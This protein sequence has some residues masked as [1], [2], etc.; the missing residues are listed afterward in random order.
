[1]RKRAWPQPSLHLGRPSSRQ[2]TPCPC[3]ERSWGHLLSGWI[4]R[5]SRSF[6]T[7]PLSTTT[8]RGLSHLERSFQTSPSHHSQER[9]FPPGEK[10][11][12]KPLTPQPG[13][14]FPAWRE[15]S[16]P[17]SHTTAR[18]D[19]SRLE[20]SFQTSPSHH[21]QERP[22]PPR[23]RLPDQP[24]TPQPGEAF[25]TWREA[26]RPAPHTTAREAL[27][28]W[29][30]L[31]DQPLSPSRRAFPPER[32]PDQPLHH[33]QEALPT[34][35]EA[36][37]PAPLTTARRGLTHLE[38]S[39][40]TSPSHHSQERP[41]PPGEK[42]PD[43]P[44]SPQPGEALPTW[45]EAPRPAPLTPA[46]RDLSH[47]E[48]GF[49]T[50]PSHH[51]QGHWRGLPDQPTPGGLPTW[52][53][54]SNQ[55]LTPQPGEALP[56]WREASQ[57]SPSHH[58]QETPP[59]ESPTR[60]PSHLER[61]RPAPTPGGLHPPGSQ[62]PS[63][64]ARKAFPTR[65]QTSPHKPGGHPLKRPA[66]LTAARRPHH[67]ER[68]FQTSHHSQERPHLERSWDKP[69]HSQARRGLSHLERSFQTSP[70][71]GQRPPRKL[72]DQPFTPGEALPGIPALPAREAPLREANQPLSPRQ[73]PPT[74]RGFQTSPSHHSQER[75]YPPG[76]KLPDQPL[77]PQPGEALPTWREASRPALHTTARRPPRKAPQPPPGRHPPGLPD[78]P[79]HP[80]QET[81]LEAPAAPLTTPEA[82]PKLQTSPLTT[83]RG[84]FP[85]GEKLPDQP[86]TP[87]PEEAFPAWGKIAPFI[88]VRDCY[89]ERC[90]HFGRGHCLGEGVTQS[91]TGCSSVPALCPSDASSSTSRGNQ[92]CLQTLSCVPG[93]S[94]SALSQRI[95]SCSV[96]PAGVQW[97]DL[98]SLKP[99]PPRF[100]QFSCL[101]FPSSWDYRNV[102][103][104]PASVCVCVCVCVSRDGVSPYWPG[105]SGTPDL[106]VRPPRPPKITGVSHCAPPEITFILSHGIVPNVSLLGKPDFVTCV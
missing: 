10:L 79:L 103:S 92:G 99:S 32:L 94:P 19:L 85:P 56:T 34:W 52:R 62:P 14:T 95:E 29:K 69:Q 60:R 65:V 102:P 82:P 64:P 58:S 71:P 67:L 37:R 73:R 49:Q 38:R 55:P 84:A 57:T 15:P 74:W 91:T 78:Q 45:R 13:E 90:E 101:S 61:P 11:P 9:P 89:P 40:Q 39:F 68:G 17:A 59:R 41:Y 54:A 18:R 28:T 51:S 12:G 46:R 47:L 4:V 50:S 3:T 105:C 83:A 66:P 63:T 106:V 21:S 43:Q 16:R 36:S 22:F 104:C 8:R 75:P 25:P 44:L 80:S 53:E 72:P 33:S 1:M 35:R 96:A 6:Q 42:L 26:S 93:V 100:K 77:T 31:P 88:E 70:P 98:G 27:P 2:Q 97:C 76:E 86:F 20:R 81:H 48:R 7:S 87:Q 24:F 5:A 30:K 23:E